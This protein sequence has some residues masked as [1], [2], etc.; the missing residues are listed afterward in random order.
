[1]NAVQ[2]IKVLIAEDSIVF[3]KILKRIL[4]KE[5]DMEVVAT[6]WNGEDAVKAARKYRPDVVSM[7]LKMPG[8]GGMKAL[9]QILSENL[10]QVVV[11]S[12]HTPRGAS[13]TMEALESGAFDTVMKPGGSGDWEI[14]V[15]RRQLVEKFRA[16]AASPLRRGFTPPTPKVRAAHPRRPRSPSGFTPT[17]GQSVLH[18][19]VVAIGISTG[20]PGA[21]RHVIPKLSPQL[22]APVFLVQH[23]PAYFLPSYVERLNEISPMPVVLVD[24]KLPVSPGVCYVGMGGSQMA[25]EKVGSKVN[26]FPAEGPRH[27]FMPSVDVMLENAFGIWG[28]RILGVIMTGMGDDGSNGAEKIFRSGGVTL[29]ESQDTCV[30][31]GMPK[32]AYDRGVVTS[33]HPNHQLAAEITRNLQGAS[34]AV[35]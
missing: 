18:G 17:S 30:V 19:Q 32:A 13:L 28:N 34:I 12:S 26:V 25:F 35:G 21:I 14:R 24:K 4:E 31:Y 23:M 2:K 7:D 22:P 1:M 16:A 8:M 11:V 9:S 29:A 20:G 33:L 15:L 27:L 5:E 6:V 3:S 10:C